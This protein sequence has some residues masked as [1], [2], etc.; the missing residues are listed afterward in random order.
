MNKRGKIAVLV[1]LILAVGIVIAIKNGGA[2]P[3]TRQP[4]DAPSPSG[5][6]RLVDLG[7]KSCVPCKMMAPILEELAAEYADTF[8]VEFIDVNKE[9]EANKAYRVML[10]PT[11]VFLD[12]FGNELFRHEGFLSKEDILDKWK[13][14]GITL[15]GKASDHGAQ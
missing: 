15:E 13:E 1:A 8:Q 2:S 9:P 3:A 14:L 6:P 4:A 7:S 10:I 5:L 12:A 11:Q